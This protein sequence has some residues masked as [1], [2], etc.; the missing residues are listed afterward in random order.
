MET[1]SLV[2]KDR[3][4]R[5]IR[6]EKSRSGKSGGYRVFYLDLPDKGKITL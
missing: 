4:L 5:K 1:A 3:S 6:V 2:F